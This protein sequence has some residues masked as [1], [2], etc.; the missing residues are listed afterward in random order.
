MDPKEAELLNSITMPAKNRLRV[1]LVW[2][3]E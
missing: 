1:V 3:L 2:F